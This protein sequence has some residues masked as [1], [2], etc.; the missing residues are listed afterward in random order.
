MI[1]PEHGGY[2]VKS[3]GGKHLGGPYKTRGEA[4]KRLE[5]VE[6]FRNQ[7]KQPHEAWKSLR[8]VK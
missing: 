5:Q 7:D 8:S 4:E 2:S 3:E 6:Y 1:V